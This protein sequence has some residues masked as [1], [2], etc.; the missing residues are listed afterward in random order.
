MKTY[1]KPRRARHARVPAFVPVP[2]RGRADG[3]TPDRQARFLAALALTGSVR[4]AARRVGMARETAYRLRRRAGAESFAAAWDKATGHNVIGRRKVTPEERV[5][6]A[7]H[8]L[9]KP[10]IYDGEHV[11]T[12]RKAD[13]SA[14]LAVLARIAQ[15]EGEAAGMPGRSQ[16][17]TARPVSTSAGAGWTRIDPVE[18]SPRA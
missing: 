16:G 1:P 6:R 13:N 15:G 5:T 2:L 11:A 3:W 9:L 12:V 8:G 17:F 18:S 14:L 7:F 10:V 4:E